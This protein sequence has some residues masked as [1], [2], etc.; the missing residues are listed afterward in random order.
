MTEKNGPE[1]GPKLNEMMRPSW[2]KRVNV[3]VSDLTIKR[4]EVMAVRDNLREIIMRGDT[5]G[6]MC[7]T[8]N[9]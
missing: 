7:T 3:M 4:H 6:D 8:I 5:G 2:I 1:N 9:F